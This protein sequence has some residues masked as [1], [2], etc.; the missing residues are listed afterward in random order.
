LLDIERAL[1]MIELVA[2]KYQRRRGRP[3]VLVINN[4]HAFGD[5]ED[6]NDLL[7]ILHQRA[8]SW[9]ATKLVTMIFNTDDYSVYERL[10]K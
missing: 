3:L 7:E 6:G 1:N 9:A 10:S 2:F 5:D 4:I 8:E